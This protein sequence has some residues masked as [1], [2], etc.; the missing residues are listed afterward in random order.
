MKELHPPMHISNTRW[1]YVTMN[2]TN[3]GTDLQKW[4]IW[5]CVCVFV[6]LPL[7]LRRKSQQTHRSALNSSALSSED[8]DGFYDSNITSILNE[9]HL[10]TSNC[11]SQQLESI[12][13]TIKRSSPVFSCVSQKCMKG[14]K[15]SPARGTR[16]PCTTNK[17]HGFFVFFLVETDWKWWYILG[18]FSCDYDC[19]SIIVFR[20]VF[21]G[22]FVA[23]SRQKKKLENALLSLYTSV[24]NISAALFSFPFAVIL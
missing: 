8:E 12:K 20:G 7:C 22:Y 17:P 18:A 13:R 11:W 1:H 3:V 10:Q 24:V 19:F 5:P 6:C 23:A 15:D 2:W 21:S 9:S 4:R 16:L 14:I